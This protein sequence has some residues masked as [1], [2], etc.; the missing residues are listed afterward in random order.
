MT[1]SR[2]A[3]F[4]PIGDILAQH[5]LPRL[6]RAQKLPLCISCIGTATMTAAIKPMVS[7][8]SLSS[9]KAHPP[10]TP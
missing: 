2:H 8:A 10:K 6:H 9:A 3:G 7:I 5:V 4:A 1:L